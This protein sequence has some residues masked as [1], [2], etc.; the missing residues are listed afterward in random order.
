MNKYTIT[1]NKMEQDVDRLYKSN[2]NLLEA[3]EKVVEEVEV[4]QPLPDL[5]NKQ[6]NP[7]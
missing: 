4:K 2:F 7:M 5:H 1:V 3:N 6:E